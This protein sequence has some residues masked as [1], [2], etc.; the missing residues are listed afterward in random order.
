MADRGV[1]RVSDTKGRGELGRRRSLRRRGLWGRGYQHVPHIEA[2]LLTYLAHALLAS[3]VL[4][5]GNGEA[6]ALRGDTPAN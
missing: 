1:P 4:V 3:R 5:V 6:A 2:D